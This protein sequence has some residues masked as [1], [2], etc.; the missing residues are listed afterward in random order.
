M[1]QYVIDE[2]RLEDYGK[3]KSYFDKNTERSNIEGIY[4]FYLDQSTLTEIQASHEDCKPFYIAVELEEEKISCELLVRTGSR[5][6]CDCIQYA[7]EAQ[8]EWIIRLIDSILEK[9][10]V[11]V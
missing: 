2:L 8:R 9:L 6:R 1:K 11:H 7:T 10:E 4:W 5:I 3:I